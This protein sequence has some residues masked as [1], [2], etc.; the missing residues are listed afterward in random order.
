M[1]NRLWTTIVG[2]VAAIAIGATCTSAAFPAFAAQGIA[3]TLTDTG[4]QSSSSVKT[5]GQPDSTDQGD[6]SI[7]DDSTVSGPNVDSQS[8]VGSEST[9]PKAE[10][11][12][13]DSCDNV[14]TWQTLDGCVSD[15]TSRTVTI[16]Q[17]IKVP[18]DATATIA[19]SVS[20]TLTAKPGVDPALTTS[21]NNGDAI[22]NV[23]SGAL[24]TI[25]KDVNDA[26]FSYKNG[27]RF[28]VYLQNGGNLTVNNGTFSGI[29]TT[30]STDHDMGTLAYSAGGT[31]TIN[32]GKFANNK[33]V[34][35]GVAYNKSGSITVNDG[36]F[37]G[38]SA[39]NGGV[40]FQTTEDEKRASLSINGGEFSN[41]KS[42][43]AGNNGGGGVLFQMR[44][45]TSITGGS[46]TGNMQTYS[47]A[48]TNDNPSACRHM[49]SGGGAIHTEAGSLTI[50]GNVKFSGNHSKAYGWGD[51][52]GAIYAQGTLWI[53]NDAWG[54]RPSF[55]GNWSG[56]YDTQ[57]IGKD[58][59]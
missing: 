12:G 26:N 52:G 47:A 17:T 11:E 23:A 48:C 15:S 6:S 31:V 59:D 2:A 18:D 5:N 22:F 36:I 43:D 39:V 9:V 35:G 24:L 4:T 21:Q 29:D 33:A 34:E 55:D 38:N 58:K 57:Y 53:R 32:G 37:S 27:K 1:R 56:I 3:G 16:A 45:T 41:N 49:R 50:A 28:L 20:I 25:G 30:G 54:N 13:Q 10:A 40:L 7:A 8:D 46:F 44:G 19:K 51:G 14:L 42:K